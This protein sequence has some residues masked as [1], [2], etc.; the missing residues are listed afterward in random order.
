MIALKTMLM[1]AG[2]LLMTVAAGIPLHGLW[3]QIRYVM[4]KKSR[5]EGMLT[6]GGT[7]EPEPA[8]IAWR[9][10]AALA[11]VACV[12]MLMAGS[13]V[14]VPSGMGGVRVSQ[15]GG[16]EPG[17]L[18]PGLHFVTPMIESVQMFDLRDHLFTAGVA[19][20]GKPGTKNNLMVQSREGLN[21]GLAVTVRYRL[22][23]NKLASVQA[24]LPQPADQQLVPPVV[25]SAW[26]ELAPGYTVREIFSSKGEE[27]RNKA[28]GMI[29]KKLS[30]DGIVVE[31]VMLS[32][33]QLPEQYAKGLEGLL[34]KEQQ[35]DQ[36]TVDTDI[37][38][39]QVRIAELQAEA[40]AKQKAKQAE[41]NAQARVI[42]AKGESDAMQYTLPLKQK[43]IEQ[44][45]LEAEAR[46]EAT[47]QNAQAEA[48]AK[49]IDSK[50]ELQR[51]NLLADAEA[52]RIKLIAQANAERMTSE[53]SLLNK[54]P[55]LINKIVAERLSDKIQVVMVPSDGK[56]FFAN[57]V[58]KNMANAPVVK[59][60][61]ESE[62]D[63]EPK[64][65]H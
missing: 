47:I 42:E 23:P 18:Y 31:E 33:I 59:Q 50:A 45:K 4:K 26:R 27:V 14:V 3:M 65:G 30:T 17:T 60:E 39:K 16:T 46:K 40:E 32:D 41:G 2:V 28:A 53:A 54:S 37:Q 10:P 21:I 1:I 38:Q 48:E 55:L 56:F 13:M 25:A 22:D 7:A 11:L 8:P 36:M 12:P 9:V 64:A 24:H 43:Q 61:M 63:T 57:D 35:D 49:V 34:L 6:D 19:D 52:S 58:F 15:I 5:G 20:A 51:R 44:T 29:T 62:S